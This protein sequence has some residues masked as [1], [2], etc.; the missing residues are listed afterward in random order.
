MADSL[1]SGSSAHS[2]RAGSSPAS[3]TKQKG[4]PKGCPFLFVPEGVGMS[5]RK[6]GSHKSGDFCGKKEPKRNG[7]A[8]AFTAR[9]WMWS[10]G[11]RCPASRTKKADQPFGWSVFLCARGIDLIRL[12]EAQFGR[13]RQSRLVPL[14]A[15]SPAGRNGFY[16]YPD[17]V[18]VF[19]AWGIGCFVKNMEYDLFL[20]S[21]R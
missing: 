18:I 11:R 17:G 12:C 7:R 4:H 3:R 14:A 21:I 20:C 5:P 10:I 9:R 8:L 19:C 1:D 2:G 15:S 6:Q 13:R 16:G